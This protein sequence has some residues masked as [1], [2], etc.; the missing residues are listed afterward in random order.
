MPEAEIVTR[1]LKD[2]IAEILQDH[3]VEITEEGIVVPRRLIKLH[4]ESRIYD[5]FVDTYAGQA[6]VFQTQLVERLT[7]SG[8]TREEYGVLF[9]PELHIVGVFNTRFGDLDREGK[10]IAFKTV[11]DAVLEMATPVAD[12][13]EIPLDKRISGRPSLDRTLK[14]LLGELHMVELNREGENRKQ[15]PHI[16]EAMYILPV[17]H[18][19]GLILPDFLRAYPDLTDLQRTLAEQI[20]KGLKMDS[21]YGYLIS[22]PI[23][24]SPL[25]QLKYV[26]NTHFARYDHQ[27]KRIVFKT[28][29]EVILEHASRRDLSRT[30]LPPLDT[31]WHRPP[32]SYRGG[33]GVA[34]YALI[35]RR[36]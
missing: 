8:K 11:N 31:P 3:T 36:N 30:D 20:M 22:H 13:K 27:T 19:E 5:D 15:D 18:K 32:Q 12:R 9:D 33:S 1:N 28:P 21:R 16:S 23:D 26:F 24:S 25:P 35:G 2:R 6:E 4:G 17:T 29:Q 7:G 10:R 14:K 34:E